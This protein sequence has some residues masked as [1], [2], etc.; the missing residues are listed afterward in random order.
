MALFLLLVLLL[1]AAIG[2]LGAVL[3]LALIL[4]LSLI[5]TVVVLSWIAMWYTRRRLRGFQRDVEIR[6]GQQRRRREAHDVGDPG[7]EGRLGGGSGRP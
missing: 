1:A 3:K 5:L 7:G 6:L 4:V 2:I